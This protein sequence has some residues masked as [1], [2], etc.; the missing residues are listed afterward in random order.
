M[1]PLQPASRSKSADE[2]QPGCCSVIPGVN[3]ITRCERRQ[4]DGSV[5]MAQRD[6]V[7]APGK[8]RRSRVNPADSVRVQARP[9]LRQVA[10]ESAGGAVVGA[11][12]YD[13]DIISPGGTKGFDRTGRCADAGLYVTLSGHHGIDRGGNPHRDA[14][15]DDQ[16]RHWRTAQVE[17]G[18]GAVVG[19]SAFGLIGGGD[20]EGWHAIGSPALP[21]DLIGSDGERSRLWTRTALHLI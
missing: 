11:G 13:G 6:A 15:A 7:H 18:E 20:F 1:N 9:Q 17:E 16:A 10:I 19:R 12:G 5:P 14:I 2:D 3:A 21:R 4:V 8:G